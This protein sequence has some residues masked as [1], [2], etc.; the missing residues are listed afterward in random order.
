MN[1]VID[2]A[3]SLPE[4]CRERATIRACESATGDES[5]INVVRVDIESLPHLL[6]KLINGC[7]REL[8]LGAHQ[9]YLFLQP[10]MRIDDA[11]EDDASDPFG[12]HCVGVSTTTE[13]YC[14]MH[15]LFKKIFPN[16][17]P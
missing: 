4:L 14:Q 13:S 15:S 6:P 8:S 16:S 11:V 9:R 10:D 1:Y 12:K 7:G 17:D 2:L 3:R 5:L